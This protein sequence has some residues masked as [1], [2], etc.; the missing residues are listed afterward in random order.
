M[1]K[2]IFQKGMKWE[3][4]TQSHVLCSQM[5]YP[6]CTLYKTMFEADTDTQPLVYGTEGADK[7]FQK[8]MKWE[9]Q[10]QPHV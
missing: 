3:A 8:D 7:K 6:C 4:Q 2:K 1:A 5:L 9:P 10:R